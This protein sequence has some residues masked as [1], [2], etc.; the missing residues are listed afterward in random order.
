MMTL[1]HRLQLLASFACI[2]GGVYWLSRGSDH[3]IAGGA[4]AVAAGA[5]AWTIYLSA[6]LEKL[7]RII[8]ADVR[9]I[10]DTLEHHDG[11]EG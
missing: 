7:V 3:E 2:G 4:V 6:T 11:R 8:A 5:L 10:A 1:R 9:R